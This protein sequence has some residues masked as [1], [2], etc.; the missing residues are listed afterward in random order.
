METSVAFQLPIKKIFAVA[1]TQYIPPLRDFR[2][3]TQQPLNTN[4]DTYAQK[5]KK[6]CE[7]E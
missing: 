5:S 3:K 4:S 6:N 1:R 7:T 2:N